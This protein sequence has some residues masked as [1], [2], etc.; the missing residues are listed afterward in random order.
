MNA[1]LYWL[2]LAFFLSHIPITCFMDSQAG[3]Q[4]CAWAR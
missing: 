1:A 3:E 2:Y 4:R